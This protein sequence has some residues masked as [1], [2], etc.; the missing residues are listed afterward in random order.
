VVIAMVLMDLRTDSPSCGCLLDTVD[1]FVD[2]TLA[3]SQRQMQQ[4]LRVDRCR[5]QI[6]TRKSSKPSTP[7]S[8]TGA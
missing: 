3:H 5:D 2:G 7:G 4:S 8:N 6:S 1:P